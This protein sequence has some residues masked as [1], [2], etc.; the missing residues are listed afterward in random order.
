MSIADKLHPSNF[1]AMSPMMAAL[2]Q[3]VVGFDAGVTPRLMAL[4][5]TSDGFV[6]AQRDGDLGYDAFIGAFSDFR[7]N[8]N[9]L[10]EA[11]ELSDEEKFLANDRFKA[12]TGREP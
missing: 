6:L 7:N 11:A 4:T 9:R 2:V 1:T 5:V 3:C 12:A 8:W 10:L